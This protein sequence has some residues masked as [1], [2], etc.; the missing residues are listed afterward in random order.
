MIHIIY[1]F[2]LIFFGITLDT[3]YSSHLVAYSY[4]M[5]YKPFVGLWEKNQKTNLSNLFFP[6]FRSQIKKYND[7]RAHYKA[8]KV[9][10]ISPFKF[11]S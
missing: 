1:N 3:V 7:P 11:I 8:Q 2:F 4:L 5:N 6:D 9:V 10:Q